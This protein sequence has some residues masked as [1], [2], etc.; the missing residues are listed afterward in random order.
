[1]KRER[2]SRKISDT[3]SKREQEKKRSPFFRPKKNFHTSLGD[4]TTSILKG[5]N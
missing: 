1:M 4:N 5:G 3:I 2:E